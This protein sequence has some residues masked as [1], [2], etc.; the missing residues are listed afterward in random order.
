[1]GTL[2]YLKQKTA[3]MARG[4]YPFQTLSVPPP[5]GEQSVVSLAHIALDRVLA[6]LLQTGN[7]VTC[8]MVL[9]WLRTT[10]CPL[11]GCVGLPVLDHARSS[12]CILKQ[13]P[14]A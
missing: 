6:W 14:K 1:M 9:A 8:L 3:K 7:R 2:S 10:I 13:P 5:H 12:R 11:P 4:Q